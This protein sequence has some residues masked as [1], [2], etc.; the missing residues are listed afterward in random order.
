MFQHQICHHHKYL[1]QS[2][3]KWCMKF[4]YAYILSLHVKKYL[5][6]W[7]HLGTALAHKQFVY[8]KVMYSKIKLNSPQE[9]SAVIFM[10]R[11]TFLHSCEY[12]ITRNTISKKWR[13]V[14]F[15]Y[16]VTCHLSSQPI[17]RFVARQ[18][19]RKHATI[20]QA[21]LGSH[22]RITMEIQ[23]EEVFSMWSAPRL[24]HASDSSILVQFQELTDSDSDSDIYKRS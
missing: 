5:P 3:L 21:L 10:L 15:Y 24:Y 19:L 14:Q 17:Q 1:I 18:Q 20:L 8:L 13:G 9:L 7:R 4:I 23:L 12:Y 2:I 6:K 16:I 22:S 11:A